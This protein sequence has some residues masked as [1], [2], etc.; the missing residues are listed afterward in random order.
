MRCAVF[1]LWLVAG[2]PAFAQHTDAGHDAP[3]TPGMQHHLGTVAF[4]NS[5]SPAAQPDFLRGVAMLQ[6]FW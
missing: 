5:C 3:D 1:A 6:T 4:A 2:A